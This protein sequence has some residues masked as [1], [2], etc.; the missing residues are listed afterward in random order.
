M[1]RRQLR[2]FIA[3]RET[4]KA[5]RTSV[6]RRAPDRRVSGEHNILGVERRKGL[7]TRPQSIWAPV[8]RELDF[9]K[10]NALSAIAAAP[11]TDPMIRSAINTSL[12]ALEIAL[13][14]KLTAMM[15]V[16]IAADVLEITSRVAGPSMTAKIMWAKKGTLTLMV[17]CA[18]RMRPLARDR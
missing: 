8:A 7:D 14:N 2:S 18:S 1:W 15:N 4:K 9:F 5:S 11:I 13:E 17:P 6:Y 12:E 16:W 10:A 3:Q